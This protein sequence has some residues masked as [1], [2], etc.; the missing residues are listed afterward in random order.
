M[1]SSFC[2]IPIC[3][4]VSILS[5]FINV[6]CIVCIFVVILLVYCLCLYCASLFIFCC[7]AEK[8]VGYR[9]TTPVRTARQ[10]S[11]VL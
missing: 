7:W 9:G 1:G 10:V 3:L 5:G 2:L 4:P 8:V 11:E 6:Y